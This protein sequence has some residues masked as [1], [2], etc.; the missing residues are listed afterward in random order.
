METQKRQLKDCVRDDEEI[1]YLSNIKKI[2]Q[3]IFQKCNKKF[4]LLNPPPKNIQ[5]FFKRNAKLLDRY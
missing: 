4:S 3:R 2:K 1:N 5:D